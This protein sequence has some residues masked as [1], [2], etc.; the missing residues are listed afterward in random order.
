MFGL[1]QLE[2]MACRKPVISTNLPTGVPWVN[3][4]GETGYT[5]APGNSKELAESIQLLL[6]SRERREDMGE[7]ARLRVEQHFTSI[8][9]A[10][11][12]LQV[13]QQTLSESYRTVGTVDEPEPQIDQAY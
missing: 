5:V 9:M 12:M 1:V 11:A 10:E 7:A 8:K 2:A 6:S 3:Q 4:H 13:Y